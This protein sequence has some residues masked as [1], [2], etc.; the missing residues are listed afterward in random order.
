MQTG[1]Q[2]AKIAKGETTLKNSTKCKGG[3]N[4]PKWKEQTPFSKGGTKGAPHSQSGKGEHYS[5][6]W[7]GGTPFT[8]IHQSA[9]GSTPLTKVQREDPIHQSAKGDPIQES[10]KG[11]PHSP[12]CKT[13]TPYTKMQWGNLIRH[14]AKR[15]GGGATH[16]PK[17]KGDPFT[18]VKGWTPFTNIHQRAK[19][20]PFTKIHQ[21]AKGEP[22]SPKCRGVTPI[23][24]VHRGNYIDESARGTS[25]TKNHQSAKGGAHFPKI[26]KGGPH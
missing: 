4:W 6:K 5:P 13:G 26:A 3:T 25:F 24:K 11:G 1:T 14:R 19:G 21:I 15:G 16:S 20:V 2:F 23:T 17:S 8:K 18:K 7:K 10:E 9:K 12:K 22:H